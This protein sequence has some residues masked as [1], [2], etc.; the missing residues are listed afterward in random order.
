MPCLNSSAWRLDVIRHDVSDSEMEQKS[1]AVFS[2]FQQ[3]YINK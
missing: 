3:I 2:T 1:D